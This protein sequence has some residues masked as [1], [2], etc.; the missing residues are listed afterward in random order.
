MSMSSHG[1]RLGGRLESTIG[2]HESRVL[3]L[4]S[5]SLD[6]SGQ[7]RGI[8]EMIDGRKERIVF[9]ADTR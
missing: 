1:G 7:S 2:G 4:P 9:T 5:Q 6:E 3:L 8:E